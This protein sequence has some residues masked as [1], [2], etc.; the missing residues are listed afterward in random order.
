MNALHDLYC[1]ECVLN[2][3]VIVTADDHA[4]FT[5]R[6]MRV[7]VLI[8]SMQTLLSGAVC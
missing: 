3:V 2:V 8:V 5:L 7:F 4:I 6:A 1:E